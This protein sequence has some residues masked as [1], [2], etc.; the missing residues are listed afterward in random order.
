MSDSRAEDEH[1]RAKE[2]DFEIIG[3]ARLVRFVCNKPHVKIPQRHV[4]V[5]LGQAGSHV[6]RRTSLTPLF[7]PLVSRLLMTGQALLL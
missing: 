4:V 2:D 5:P 3:P 7:P 6:A 1:S